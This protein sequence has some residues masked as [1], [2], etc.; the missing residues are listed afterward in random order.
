MNIDTLL[1]LAFAALNFWLFSEILR[2][3]RER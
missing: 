3:G 2:R 1:L